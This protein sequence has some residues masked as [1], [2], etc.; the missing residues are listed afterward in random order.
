MYQNRARWVTDQYTMLMLGVFPLFW[1]FEG[2]DAVTEWKF[3][4]FAVA[5]GLWLGAVTVLLLLGAAKGERYAFSVRAGHLFMGLFL[6]MGA[7][8]AVTSEYGSLCLMG[9]SRNTGYFTMVLYGLIFFGVSWLGQPRRS[10]IWAMAVAV[11]VSCIIAAIQ[12][13]GLNPL[14]L[15]PAGTSYYDK[16]VLW[17]GAF[18]GTM[19]NVGLFSAHLSLTV[20]VLA[21]FALRSPERKDRLY[22]LPAVLGLVLMILCDVEAGLVGLAVSL[23][24]SVPVLIRDRRGARVAACVSGSAALGGLGLVYVWPG[25]GGTLWEMSQVLHGKLL[26]SFGSHRGQIWKRCW[27]LFRQKPWLGAGPGTAAEILN[28][29]WEG[30]RYITVVD[31]AH[32]VYLG[33]LIEI[34]LVGALAYIAA[35]FSAVLTWVRRRDCDLI[36]AFGCGLIAYLVQDF[37]GLGLSITAPMLFVVWGLVES[38]PPC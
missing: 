5:T 27:E 17:A 21:A 6:V 2:Y 26:D 16:Y 11:T 15:Y 23:L 20:P 14:G 7:F 3:R 12:L 13:F 29:R 33:Y 32:N 24:V 4:F 8:S 19:G 31:N 1:G 38:E 18:L 37:F 34:G 36:A 35:A 28:I 25:T 9:A 10:H 30:Q 22:L